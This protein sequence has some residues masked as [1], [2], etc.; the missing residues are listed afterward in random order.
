VDADSRRVV[1]VVEMLSPANKS[2]GKDGEAYLAKRQD[3]LRTHTNLVEIDFLRRGRRPPVEVPMPR[4]DYYIIVCRGIDYPQAGVW[5][6]SVRDRLPPI[7]IPLDPGV[8]S[9]KLELEPCFQKAYEEGRYDL[10]VNY[11]EPPTA[12]LAEPDA[13]WAKEL[14]RSSRGK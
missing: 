8:I 11:E 4:A 10:D 2:T 14:I 1:T 7:P 5:P 12:P 13:T 9:V 6:L 3:Y